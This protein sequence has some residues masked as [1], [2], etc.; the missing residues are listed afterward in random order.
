MLVIYMEFFSCP[1]N[2]YTLTSLTQR[3]LVVKTYKSFRAHRLAVTD[4]RSEIKDS[5]F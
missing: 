4:L 3:D 1:A 5:R 2:K